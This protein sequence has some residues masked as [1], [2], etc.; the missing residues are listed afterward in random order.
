MEVKGRQ[1]GAT[2]EI[3]SDGP[4]CV[5]AGVTCDRNE[6]T[7]SMNSHHEDS[8]GGFTIK[9]YIEVKGTEKAYD[10]GRWVGSSMRTASTSGLADYF[11]VEAVNADLRPPRL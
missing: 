1:G 2:D 6:R 11:R 3:N 9:E 7:D 4:I 8:E 5:Y 10:S